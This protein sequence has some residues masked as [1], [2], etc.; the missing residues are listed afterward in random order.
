MLV[1]L[2]YLYSFFQ[3]GHLHH[4]NSII[5]VEVF[6]A[7]EPCTRTVQSQ[8]V[9]YSRRMHRIV[10]ITGRK[11]NSFGSYLLSENTLC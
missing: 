3:L 8:N 6:H 1:D 5:C 10:Y 7:R 2:F 4:H 11:G 9:G